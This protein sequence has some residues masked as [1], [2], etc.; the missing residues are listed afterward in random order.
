M[1]YQ[2]LVISPRGKMYRCPFVSIRFSN[3]E[4][5]RG[6]ADARAG[7]PPAAWAGYYFEGYM[8]VPIRERKK[9]DQ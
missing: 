1:F 4:L 8:S 5:K 3:L 7:H 9:R 6:E 2:E